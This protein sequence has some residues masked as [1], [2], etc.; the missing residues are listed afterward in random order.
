MLLE[1]YQPLSQ[2]SDVVL[3]L[4]FAA[5][6]PTSGLDLPIDIFFLQ[7]GACI[8]LVFSKSRN[9]MHQAFAVDLVMPTAPPEKSSRYYLF[10]NTATAHDG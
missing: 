5:V 2:A 10:G 6:Q 7:I 1:R 9:C 3:R 4:T 8:A